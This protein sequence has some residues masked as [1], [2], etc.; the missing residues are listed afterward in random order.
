MPKFQ[1]LRLNRE[2]N[3]LWLHSQDWLQTL[4]A[5]PPLTSDLLVVLDCSMED[6]S[7]VNADGNTMS[8]LTD[9]DYDWARYSIM[10]ADYTQSE[11]T[12]GRLSEHLVPVLQDLAVSDTF[13]ARRGLITT[14]YVMKKLR[15]SMRFDTNMQP[16]LAGNDA[17]G[18]V[19]LVPIS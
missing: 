17:R 4:I 3:D 8:F 9:D 18:D 11:D 19:I 6:L 13:Y 2:D 10:F 12:P 15:T 1:W 5:I 16:G 14:N 7:R